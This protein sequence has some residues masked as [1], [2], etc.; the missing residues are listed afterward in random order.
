M[1]NLIE[2]EIKKLT[3]VIFKEKDLIGRGGSATIYRY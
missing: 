1:K 2:K 3:K